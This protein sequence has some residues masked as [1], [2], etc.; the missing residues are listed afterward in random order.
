MTDTT[1]AT[2]SHAAAMSAGSTNASSYP[3][4]CS[5]SGTATTTTAATTTAATT[6]TTTSEQRPG[7]CDQQCRYCGYCKK[8][9]HPRHDDLL[10]AL[11]PRPAPGYTAGLGGG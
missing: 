2:M 1:N 5:R 6:T 11:T 9:C 7:R 3:A 4:T 10:F 8:L